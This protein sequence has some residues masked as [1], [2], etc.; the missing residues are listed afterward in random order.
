LPLT[1]Q[2]LKATDVWARAKTVSDAGNGGQVL[3]DGVTFERVK[4]RLQAR[5]GGEGR[6]TGR[7]CWGRFR[8]WRGLA[9]AALAPCQGRGH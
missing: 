8:G 7:P 4:D 5:G 1:R 9:R 2:E 3:I 6:V